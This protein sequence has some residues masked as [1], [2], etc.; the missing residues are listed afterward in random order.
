MNFLK[1]VFDDV[2]EHKNCICIGKGRALSH[3]AIGVNAK[4]KG[5]WRSVAVF[6]KFFIV[7]SCDGIGPS[8]RFA[9]SPSSTPPHFPAPSLFC[10]TSFVLCGKLRPLLLLL[11]PSSAALPRPTVHTPTLP[12]RA[13]NFPPYLRVA[14]HT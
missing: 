13:F 4:M 5:S 12:I 9:L 7:C 8:R 10:N 11:H 14:K 2:T 6:A 3:V 1:L